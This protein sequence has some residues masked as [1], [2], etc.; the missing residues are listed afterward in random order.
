MGI[1]LRN[2]ALFLICLT[3]AIPVLAEC[4]E[5]KSEV[6]LMTPSGITKTICVSDKAI[7]GIENAAEQSGA[8][9]I[10]AA[11]PCLDVWDGEPYPD[12][13][14]V[15][16]APGYSVYQLPDTLPEGTQCNYS[17]VNQAGSDE[18]P[19]DIYT[20]VEVDVPTAADPDGLGHTLTALTSN[21]ADGCYVISHV[22]APY[23]EVSYAGLE[24]APA[25]LFPDR[26]LTTDQLYYSSMMDACRAELESRG[27]E[28]Q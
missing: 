20:S 13:T 4:P 14:D 5:G 7:P 24:V 10:E 21:L 6:L 8:I 15:Y 12:G 19:I 16:A 18:L 22:E 1:Y 28:F 9:R 3:T 11:C 23:N 26:V 25:A 27:C 17:Q 2:A